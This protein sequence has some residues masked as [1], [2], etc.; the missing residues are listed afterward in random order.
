MS[1][2]L[3]T[4]SN[5]R[6]S[7]RCPSASP[8]PL[9]VLI[10]DTNQCVLDRLSHFL[11][12]GIPSIAVS[13]CSSHSYAMHSLTI[14]RYQVVVCGVQ[15]AAAE[16]FSLL[17][18]HRAFQSSVPFIVIAEPQ[19]RAIAQCALDQGI[20]DIIVWPIQKDQVKESIWESLW[21]YQMR[22]TIFH[23]KHTLDALRR[24]QAIAPDKMPPVA[25]IYERLP[26]P[27]SLRAYQRT[28]QRLE[29]NL[30]YVT[31]M[32]EERERQGREQLS[33]WTDWGAATLNLHDAASKSLVSRGDGLDFWVAGVNVG[34][35]NEAPQG[36]RE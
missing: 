30:N 1:H 12:S 32:G 8:L 33:I 23:R 27:K 2:S 6:R 3:G 20:E 21:L 5:E 11:R 34:L 10:A 14:A 16:G 36:V 17:K 29:T 4:I 25:P 24:W 22:L 7:D 18:Q 26:R 13:L 31:S 19:D 35:K 15:L 9:P 28:V